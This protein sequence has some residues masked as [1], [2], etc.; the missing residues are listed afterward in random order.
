M[1]SSPGQQP[2]CLHGLHHTGL[3]LVQFLLQLIKEACLLPNTPLTHTAPDHEQ[4]YSTQQDSTQHR[5][6]YKEE[7]VKGSLEGDETNN[8]HLVTKMHLGGGGGGSRG[9]E[10]GRGE[11]EGMGISS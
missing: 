9:E 6:D 5:E 2:T 7:V 8:S 3:N 4:Q 1:T 11:G 10:K